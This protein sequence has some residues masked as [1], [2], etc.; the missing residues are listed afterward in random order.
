MQ[1]LSFLLGV[2]HCCIHQ[3]FD[4]WLLG[5]FHAHTPFSSVKSAQVL[6]CP[7]EWICPSHQYLRAAPFPLNMWVTKW[8]LLSLSGPSL[9][10]YLCKDL[11]LIN[12]IGKSCT[13]I[14]LRQLWYSS[15]LRCF[16]IQTFI[17]IWRMSTGR[18]TIKLIQKEN[19]NKNKKDLDIEKLLYGLL[20]F[21]IQN[22]IHLSFTKHILLL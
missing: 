22:S 21:F 12:R 11:D 5:Q 13:S 16:V 18:L 17:P 6:S 9:Q 4:Y 8:P 7:S 19:K 20:F 2:L 14:S 15:L 1:L 3:I 10:P